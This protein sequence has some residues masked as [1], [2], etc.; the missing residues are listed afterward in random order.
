MP[1]PTARNRR[2]TLDEITQ[3]EARQRAGGISSTLSGPTR[4]RATLP[5]LQGAPAQGA[6]A[7][8][9]EQAQAGAETVA[10]TAATTLGVPSQE[11][12]QQSPFRTAAT[13]GGAVLGASAGGRIVR[14]ASGNLLRSGSPL[15][16]RGIEVFGRALGAGVGSM[17]GGEITR[18]AEESAPEAISRRLWDGALGAGGEL[19]SPLGIGAVRGV[20]ALPSKASQLLFGRTARHAP[21]VVPHAAEVQ[22]VL[23]RYGATATA[24]QLRTD[25]PTQMLESIVESSFAGGPQVAAT[26]GAGRLAALQ[27]WRDA[28]PKLG[29]NLPEEQVGTLVDAAILNSRDAQVSATRAAYTHARGVAAQAGVEDDVVFMD[30]VYQRF[31]ANEA[32]Q[33]RVKAGDPMALSIKSTLEN[34]LSEP[35]KVSARDLGPLA[36]VDPATA[37][38]ASGRTTRT[39]PVSFAQAE[40]MRS[41]LLAIA[42]SSEKEVIQGTAALA[43]P[44]AQWV[45]EAIEVAT[46]SLGVPEVRSAYL[47]A[48][49]TAKAGHEVFNDAILGEL[50]GKAR[51]EQ[52]AQS[53][54]QAGTPS[55]ITSLYNLIRDPKYR[56]AIGNPEELIQAIQNGWASNAFLRA[57]G[58]D[59]AEPSGKHLLRTL[60][61]SRGTFEA[62]FPDAVERKSIEIGARALELT[63]SKAGGKAGTV[64]FQLKQAGAASD[65]LAT[66]AYM[67]VRGPGAE[68][69]G[70]LAFPAVAAIPLTSR[71]VVNFMLERALGAEARKGQLQGRLLSQYMARLVDAARQDGIPFSY[72]APNGETTRFDPKETPPVQG[73]LAPTAAGRF[74]PVSKIQPPPQ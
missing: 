52:I 18:R 13:I 36:F 38:V 67:G 56:T 22:E 11:E 51:P 30:E 40:M 69:L 66:I 26:K 19:A 25:Y 28:L 31:R 63:Q 45:D 12:F 57:G 71:R 49:A 24:G 21:R 14:F 1:D 43:K 17:A 27:A 15:F 73:P 65:V 61:H 53:L 34:F 6:P 9:L 8:A 37:L 20:R 72:I 50:I 41:E 70:I 68:A 58:T 23:G 5:F 3:L 55:R 29:Q 32:I 64:F 60:T 44:V 33:N 74:K 59:F 54:Y 42:R 4:A 16:Q 10:Q 2:W 47:A 62:T 46:E 7:Q 35:L 48:R 39:I